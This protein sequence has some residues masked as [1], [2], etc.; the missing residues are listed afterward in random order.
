VISNHP[1]IS[2]KYYALKALGYTQKYTQTNF[3]L[4]N[5]LWSRIPYLLVLLNLLS[6]FI[7]RSFSIPISPFKSSFCVSFCFFIGVHIYLS[8]KYVWYHE[9]KWVRIHAFDLLIVSEIFLS[10]QKVLFK[11]SHKRLDACIGKS[12]NCSVATGSFCLNS[13]FF[14][15]LCSH[16]TILVDVLYLHHPTQI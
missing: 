13:L 10:S 4:V 9:R 2:H 16:F 14:L 15:Q 3:D 1:L 7:I 5:Q 8:N 6:L 12:C 11:N